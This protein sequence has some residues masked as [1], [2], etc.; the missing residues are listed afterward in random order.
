MIRKSV[1]AGQFYDSN[2]VKLRKQLEL[3]LTSE[4]QPSNAI[5]IISPH[6]GYVYSGKVAAVTYAKITIPSSVIILCPNHY[7]LGADA[8]VYSSGSWETPLGTIPVNESLCEALLNNCSILKTDNT[9]HSRE[10]SLEVQLPFIQMKTDNFSIVP[11][12]LKHLNLVQCKT[13]GSSLANIVKPHQNEILII[14]SSDMSHYE[15]QDTAEKLDRLALESY[16][17]MNPENFFQTIQKY[18]I[19]MCGF[20]PATCLLYAALDL[21]ATRIQ[22]VKYMTSGEVSGDYSRVVGYA[23]LIIS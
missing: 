1:W 22:T 18:Q 3:L 23:G 5:G 16:T 4:E 17:S 11:I 14:A 8:A 2:P 19:S 6:A 20:I 10:H 12:C 21:G 15:S 7:G 13:I 9:A